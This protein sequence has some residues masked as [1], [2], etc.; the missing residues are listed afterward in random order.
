MGDGARLALTGWIERLDTPDLRRVPGVPNLAL[1]E[2]S[3]VEPALRSALIDEILGNVSGQV[4]TIARTLLTGALTAHLRTQGQG[5]LVVQS[6]DLK[7]VSS[8]DLRRSAYLDEFAL[9]LSAYKLERQKVYDFRPSNSR[10]RVLPI[11][12]P[13]YQAAAVQVLQD[14]LYEGH[15]FVQ[16]WETDRILFVPAKKLTALK[17]G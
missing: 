5:P 15:V 12:H 1:A 8:R 9:L 14:A 4:K 3:Q 13:A 16:E 10:L 17:R 6:P 11:T 7:K 2:L